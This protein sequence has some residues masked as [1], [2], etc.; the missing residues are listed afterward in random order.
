[1]RMWKWMCIYVTSVCTIRRLLE[2]NCYKELQKFVSYMSHII[3]RMR[4]LPHG[5]FVWNQSGLT[6]TCTLTTWIFS[7]SLRKFHSND[8]N[9]NVKMREKKTP[10]RTT[11]KMPHAQLKENHLMEATSLHVDKSGRHPNKEIEG[12]KFNTNTEKQRVRE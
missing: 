11:T 10:T 9:G 1:M 12:K 7:F 4:L 6:W 2:C 3:F 8:N 5:N